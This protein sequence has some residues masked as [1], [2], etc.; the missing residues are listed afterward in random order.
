ME[1]EAGERLR[2]EVHTLPINERGQFAV[3][4]EVLESD[5][6]GGI[7]ASFGSWV[8][9]GAW[10]YRVDATMPT[11]RSTRNTPGQ[12]TRERAMLT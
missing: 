5:V 4:E 10:F 6:R 11:V 1:V 3:P 12:R 7:E 9:R 8:G 2:E